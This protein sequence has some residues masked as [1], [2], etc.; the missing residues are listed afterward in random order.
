M[1]SLALSYKLCV[2]PHDSGIKKD[3]S[4]FFLNLAEGL[5]LQVLG[6]IDQR[7]TA[8]LSIAIPEAYSTRLTMSLLILFGGLSQT[9][10]FLRVPSCLRLITVTLQFHMKSRKPPR[11]DHFVFHLEKLKV[12][13]CAQKYVVTP[14]GL[15]CSTSMKTR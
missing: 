1:F 3:N 15:E 9:A 10:G 6:I 12:L 5:K 4:P 13:I 7:C 11:C 14:I 2:D 8:G